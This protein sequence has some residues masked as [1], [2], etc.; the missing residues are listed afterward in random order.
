MPRLTDY[1]L[2]DGG[3]KVINPNS[4]PEDAWST[5]TGGDEKVSNPEK[6]YSS[7][8]YVY[9]CVNVRADAVASLPWRIDRLGSKNQ[10]DPVWDNEMDEAPKEFSG[11]EDFSDY[12]FLTE[13]SLCL[14]ARAYWFKIGAPARTQF[15][16]L[17]A[18]T[19]TNKWDDQ[20]GLTH[21]ERRLPK[22]TEP[23]IISR[24]EMVY[25]SLKNPLH[26]TKPAP[27]PVQAALADAGV[28]YN[29]D[30][31]AEEF[32]R[33]GAIKATL[34]S[35][36]RSMSEAQRKELKSWWQKIVQGTKT[37]WNTVVLSNDVKAT[38]IGEGFSELSNQE[39]V[40]NK[41]EGISTALGVPHSLV[42][43]NAA[44]YA[45]ANQDVQS[46]YEFTVI[47][48]AK[49][50]AAT[51]NR[52]LFYEMGYKFTF[53]GDSLNIFQEDENQRSAAFKTY[54]DAGLKKSLAAELLGMDL[55]RN[56]EYAELDE[57]DEEQRERERQDF[58]MQ[59][60]Q[61]Q[62]QMTVQ[63]MPKAN[64][65]LPADEEK[66]KEA[67]Q[68][69]AWAKKRIG[70]VS[71]DPEEFEAEYLSLNDKMGILKTLGYPKEDELW[72]RDYP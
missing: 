22:R 41:Q 60:A 56:M 62:A 34:L 2:F 25:F 6:F 14:V 59:Q 54:V 46:F 37:A 5:L 15:R 55:P 3:L 33:R 28:I 51:L 10:E 53:L 24:E 42:M 23:E 43:S 7:V 45:T 49:K 12:L 65:S 52:D 26:E 58:Q 19:I 40:R 13:A 68:Y 72:E 44:S 67:K 47:P 35:V 38:V 29:M 9:R 16:W 69:K 30:K 63:A 11:F 1:K 48:S 36:D 18:T 4:F 70:K 8:G 50:I 71:F 32:F 57:V 61:A 21:F 64:S 17:L 27:S 20:E 66:V 39:L 31:F